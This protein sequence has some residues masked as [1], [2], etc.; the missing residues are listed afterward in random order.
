MSDK[1]KI[2]LRLTVLTAA[3]KLGAAE[4]LVECEAFAEQGGWRV[5]AQFVCSMGSPYLLA[6]GM[7]APVADAVTV[8][9][10]PAVGEW[11]VWVRTRDWTPDYAGV[12]PGRFQ[13]I[14]DGMVMP[15]ELG[16]APATWGWVDAGLFTNV[17][18]S[19][20][21]RLHDL[22]G[23]DGRC[24]A[25][26]FT[27]D[28][29]AS[30]P[31]TDEVGLASWRAMQ[32][33]ETL[34]PAVT[35]KYDFVVVGGGIAGTCAALAAAEKGLAVA[36]IQDR[37]VLGGNA[38][39]E[40]RVATE[41]EE[42]HRIVSSVSNPAV[43]G[44]ADS[45]A[46]DDRRMLTVTNQPNITCLTRW[47]AYN[48]EMSSTSTIQAVYARNV[49]SGERRRFVGEH[50]ADCT[51]D[52]WLGYWSG[53]EYAM[54]REARATYGES[55]APVTADAMTMGNSLMWNTS[56]TGAP[57]PFPA[58]PW[59]MSVAGT[60][61]ATS[62]GWDWEYGMHLSTIYDAEEIRDHLLRA[63]YGNFYNAKQK[64]ANANRAFAWVPYV[65]G[66][67]E[68][69]RIVG[70]YLLT[71]S[72][73]VEGRWFEDAVG[74]ATW[75]IDLHFPKDVSYR[76][77]F[78]AT[79]V[80]R[81]FFPYR[82]LYS[83]DIA[84]L[85]MAGR[86]ISVSHV[87][88]GSPRVMNTCGQMG[89]AIGYAAWLC[90]K[91]ACTP[92]DIYRSPAKTEELQLTIGGVWPVRIYVEPE[93]P[94]VEVIVDNLDA[95]IS[96]AWTIST[97]EAGQFHGKNYLH[98]GDTGKSSNK[99]VRFT[100]DL[101]QAGIYE[102]YVIWSASL[103][104]AG[105]VPIDIVSAEGTN[106]MA[107]NMQQRGGIWNRLGQLR[108][109]AGRG[110]SV[111]I[112]TFG[113]T[114]YVIADAVKFMKID[115][116][117]VDNLDA[118]ISG[119]WTI[120]T[121]EAGKFHGANYLHNAQA[122]SANLWV[123][124]VPDIPSTKSYRLR[125]MWN[126]ADSRSTA[127]KEEIIHAD[128]VAVI[129]VNMTQ[130][131][132]RWNDIGVYRFAA[133][134]NGS[135]RVL[136]EGSAGKHVIADAVRWDD[137]G[138]IIIDNSDA[139]TVTYNGAWVA[140]THHAARYGNN[141]LHNNRLIGEDVWV[142]YTPNIHSNRLYA[143]KMFW[144]QDSSREARVPVEIVHAGGTNVVSVDMTTSGGEWNTLGVYHFAQGTGG[145]IRI[146]TTNTTGYIIADAIWL[147]PY[148]A[149]AVQNDW[150]G[151]GLDDNWERYH[152]LNAGG[153]DPDGD[154]DGDGLTNMGEFISGCDPNDKSSFFSIRKMLCE[155]IPALPGA[156]AIEINW[157]SIAGRSYTVQ[158]STAPGG[159][160]QRLESNIPA[161]PPM[162]AY[163]VERTLPRG[164]FKVVVDWPME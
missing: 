71:Q 99:W 64:A 93:E 95:E 72:E 131:P 68:S 156:S 92:R 145:S 118:E 50:F 6:H 38:S 37:P 126:G 75:G 40:I 150:D 74:S 103:N 13:L 48:V 29:A 67:R 49:E 153:V 78:T 60:A 45:K 119:A 58:V 148:K 136:T 146:Q 16:V 46:W 59:A 132:G 5:D 76:A 147:E 20:Q 107:V 18:N 106:T 57:V 1:R 9:D 14:L 141:Y 98:D 86:N 133:G 36:L 73:I 31:P 111:Q 87:G 102:V 17:K 26:Y 124:Y 33:G 32:K 35:E 82:C 160:Y 113:T 91:Y 144:N 89:V 157:P 39:S 123:K 140:S 130:N 3:I 28:A 51:G 10:L 101:P 155:E 4:L 54:G 7:G 121:S 109:D 55:R 96:G 42:R 115:S 161:T 25:V 105:N 164:F 21:L 137:R 149:P 120:S 11:R 27:S 122:A 15:Q 47:R 158:W 114:S 163:Q 90:D 53:A 80:G 2:V 127:V 116:L 81:W 63:I 83:R 117:V 56:D 142:K 112:G 88:L 41:G 94:G 100:P 135:L 134:T 12:K 159:V 69:R 84:N 61:A 85:F 77:G 30:A 151:N 22:T 62:G 154:P 108:F 138:D 129:T 8:A 65:A 143:V 162:N 43:N 152:F 23:F 44:S 19:V 125:Q 79:H 128:G 24:D 34:V 110:G 139:D 66:K 97:S 70:D 52:G 104:R